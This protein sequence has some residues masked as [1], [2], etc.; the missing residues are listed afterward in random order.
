VAQCTYC[1]GR[2]VSLYPNGNKIKKLLVCDEMHFFADVYFFLFTFGVV[3]WAGEMCFLQHTEKKG[4][5]I[6]KKTH[7]IIMVAGRVAALRVIRLNSN[8][9][10][11]RLFAGWCV[12][13]SVLP[14]TWISTLFY[15]SIFCSSSS[16]H[17]YYITLLRMYVCV[18]AAFVQ[19][20]ITVRLSFFW[21]L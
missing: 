8:E 14:T 1:R 11:F 7:I 13:V 2:Y 6:E 17:R 15:L 12:C 4:I 18:Y 21:R 9:R 3:C 10:K 5:K 16:Y 20:G 19:K